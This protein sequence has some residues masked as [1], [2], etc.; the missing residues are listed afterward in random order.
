MDFYTSCLPLL[1]IRV[2]FNCLNFHHQDQNPYIDLF[3]YR[4]KLFWKGVRGLSLKKCAPFHLP[5]T[6]NI[7]FSIPAARTGLGISE[8]L[9]K[10]F[11]K[12]VSISF[13][14][15]T[16]LSSSPTFLCHS[17]S[18]YLLSIAKPKFR[19]SVPSF[20][21]VCLQPFLSWLY[22]TRTR[23]L[24]HQRDFSEPCFHELQGFFPFTLLLSPFAF[25]SR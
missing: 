20:L 25:L 10:L 23:F 7:F 19:A 24:K 17:G 4:S 6:I 22:I 9:S 12:W 2:Y 8:V 13:S 16:I 15:V 11:I 21:T 3:S 1:L 5:Q 18:C 14:H